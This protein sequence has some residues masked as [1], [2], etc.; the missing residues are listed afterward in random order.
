MHIDISGLNLN[1][2]IKP[3]IKAVKSNKILISIHLNDNQLETAV[4]DFVMRTMGI[5]A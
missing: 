5:E 1:N 4:R 3:I 2:E